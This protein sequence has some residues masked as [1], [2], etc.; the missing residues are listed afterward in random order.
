MADIQLFVCSHKS[1]TVPEH[2][3]LKP[4]QVGAALAGE[5]FQGF[6]HDDEGENISARNRTYC[7]LTGQYWAWKNI[8]ADWYGFFHY[9]RYLYPDTDTRLPYI[10]RREPRPDRMGYDRFAE[11]IEQYDM[12][13]PIG[14]EMYVSVREHY[15]QAHCA[16]DLSLTEELLGQLYPEMAQA[17]ERYLSGGRCLFGNIF[18]MKREVFRDYCQWLFQLLDAFDCA[19]DCRRPRVDG[20]LAERMLGVYAAYRKRDLRTL[21][22]P[23]IH[24][25]ERREYV[26]QRAINAILPPGTKIRARIKRAFGKKVGDTKCVIRT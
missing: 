20:Y 24:F 2:V 9:R 11:L 12:I 26:T 14:E 16:K 5:H 23:R 15:A 25:C 18:I 7:E 17:Q 3:L 6:L 22:L 4:L 21:E 19:V 8:Q 13:L 1:T 10:I